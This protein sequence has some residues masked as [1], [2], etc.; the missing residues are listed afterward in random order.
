M[1]TVSP[2]SPPLSLPTLPPKAPVT[3]SSLLA[4]ILANSMPSPKLLSNS[5][6]SSWLVVSTNISKSPP[7]SAM[8]TRAPIVFT[9]TFISSTWKCLSSTTAKSS[10]VL[11]NPSLSTLPRNTATKNLSYIPNR[12]KNILSKAAKFLVCPSISLWTPTAST[13]LTSA[14]D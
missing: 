5:S 10:A 9:V 12:P 4:Y 13:N 1:T 7:V 6:N 3:F 14:T 11:S 2:K 8:K